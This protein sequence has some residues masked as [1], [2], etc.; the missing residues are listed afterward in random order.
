M[1][2]AKANEVLILSKR[3]GA[4]EL[5]RSGFV[6]QILAAEDFHEQVLAKVLSDFG[7]H[8]NS[9]SLLQIKAL[10]RR[11]AREMNDRVNVEEVMGGLA[12]FE[13]GIPQEEFR[14]LSSGEKKHKL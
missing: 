5:L 2:L 9:D 3:I 11:P 8:L 10:I 6:H 14:K 1:G 4:K 13:A 12:R 7:D